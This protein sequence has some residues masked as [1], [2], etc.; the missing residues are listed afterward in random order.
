MLAESILVLVIIGVASAI[1]IFMTQEP[2]KRITK[3][4]VARLRG[5]G[6]TPTKKKKKGKGKGKKKN[7][8][9][10]SYSLKPKKTKKIANVKPHALLMQGFFGHAEPVTAIGFYKKHVFTA[11]TDGTMRLWKVGAKDQRG[12]TSTNVDGFSMRG[13]SLVTSPDGKSHIAVA[14]FGKLHFYRASKSDG[15]VSFKKKSECKLDLN[16]EALMAQFN[17]EGTFVIV[18]GHGTRDPFLKIVNKSGTVLFKDKIN[19]NA[20][21]QACLSPCGRWIAV[22]GGME[23]V[24]LWALMQKEGVFLGCKRALQ[25][26]GHTGSVTCVT[27]SPDCTKALTSSADGKLRIFHIDVRWKDREDPKLEETID[28][29]APIDYAVMSTNVICACSNTFMYILDRSNGK[30]LETIDNVQHTTNGKVTSMIIA[31]DE[32]SVL[33]GGTDKHAYLYKLPK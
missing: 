4:D 29:G 33:V 1:Y 23:T 7:A 24:N 13:A 16:A 22:V 17:Q 8:P 6:D 25:L 14:T 18:V 28:V 32:K 2:E 11:S 26:R 27:F 10:K 20:L 31:D 12:S 30:K 3:A 9:S 21:N 19:E 15:K 5:G